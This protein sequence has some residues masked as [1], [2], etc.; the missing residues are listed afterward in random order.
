[1]PK[2]RIDFAVKH[3]LQVLNGESP[4]LGIMAAEFQLID[5]I[6]RRGPGRHQRIE[7]KIDVILSAS[8]PNRRGWRPRLSRWNAGRGCSSSNRLVR[9][10]RLL[11][12]FDLFLQGIDLLALSL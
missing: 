1:A 7:R 11:E 4:L 2:V 8:Q 3:R 12:S 9:Q 6:C 10:R 5:V